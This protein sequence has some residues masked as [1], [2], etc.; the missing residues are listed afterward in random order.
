M[1]DGNVRMEF[2][3]SPEVARYLQKN[4]LAIL[5]VGCFEMHGP[6]VPL[7]CDTMH[8]HAM[9]VILAE[10]W[11]CVV[12]P[13]I[14]FSY[15]G[16]SGPWPGTIAPRPSATQAWVKEICLAALE[17]GFQRLVVLGTHGP[18]KFMLASVIR[19]IHQETGRLVLHMAPVKLMPDDLMMESLGYGRGEDILVLASA[20]ILGLPAGLVAT[21]FPDSPDRAFPFPVQGKLNQAECQWPWTFTEPWQHQPVRSCVKPEHAEAA[22]EVMRRAA[23]RQYA[24]L[25]ADFAAYQQ[26]MAALEDDPPWDVDKVAAMRPQ[27]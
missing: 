18:L 13:P 3:T 8:A 20:K 11:G 4:D 5:P 25:P 16:A 7:G 9:S 19:E 10:L 27:E 15:P 2:M 24:D 6:H 26:A 22:V 17:A 1:V 23:R 12:L 14:A 21:G